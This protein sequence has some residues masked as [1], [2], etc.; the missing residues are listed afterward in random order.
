ML[1]NV[2][3]NSIV[4]QCAPV[5]DWPLGVFSNPEFQPP[6]LF[7]MKDTPRSSENR[8]PVSRL[9]QTLETR[10]LAYLIAAGGGFCALSQV[11]HAQIVYT[12]GN[13]PMSEAVDG[14]GVTFTN[15]DLNNDG[16]PDFVFSNYSYATL[17]QGHRYLKIS[18]ASPGNEV[19]QVESNGRSFAAALPS[20]VKVGSQGNFQ[21]NPNG[22]SMAYQMY[23]TSFRKSAGSWNQIEFGF[24][25][26]KFIING[27][28]HFG[29]AR[30]KFVRPQFIDQGSISGYAYEATPNQPIITGQTK[31][32]LEQ[33]T[34]G[35]GTNPANAQSLGML[36][37][38]VSGL[39][40]WRSDPSDSSSH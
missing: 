10:V 9:G 23:R 32:T 22:F 38:G 3:P 17:G 12:P 15:F 33:D 7:P 30:V 37:V 18:P 1:T 8:R 11:S 34:K 5:H 25:G 31:E 2:E 35:K 4:G 21:S 29:W 13:I 40:T 16:T 28:I 24:L 36:A 39:N 6:E 19:F 26:L 14:G 20:G 27:Q